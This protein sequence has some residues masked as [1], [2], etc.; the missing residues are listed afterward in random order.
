[1]NVNKIC[2][3]FLITP[4]MTHQFLKHDKNREFLVSGSGNEFA[5]GE[6]VTVFFKKART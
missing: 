3:S 6:R 1:M 2:S 5:S 4:Q